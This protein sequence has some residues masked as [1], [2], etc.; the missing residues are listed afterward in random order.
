[1]SKTFIKRLDVLILILSALFLSTGTVFASATDSCASATPLELDAIYRGFADESTEFH[2]LNVPGAG[3]V[4]LDVTV[5]G[6][7]K[8]EP[9]LGFL[10]RS[11][12]TAADPDAATID[13]TAAH[14]VIAFR[15]AGQ[16]YLRVAAQDPL[17][18]L[19]DYKV[20]TRFA[21]AEIVDDSFETELGREGERFPVRQ[22]DFYVDRG[23]EP[24]ASLFTVFSPGTQNIEDEPVDPDPNGIEDEPVDPD[25]NGFA[26]SDFASKIEDEPVDPDPNGFQ[27]NGRNLDTFVV[28][29]NGIGADLCRGYEADDHGDVTDCATPLALATSATGRIGN[30]WNDDVDVFSVTLAAPASLRIATR[31]SGDTAGSLYDRFGQ[32]LAMDDDSGDGTNFR[33]AKTLESG[34]Y[35]IRVEG[36]KGAAGSYELT[37][38]ALDW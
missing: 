16:Y 29:G 38:E 33:I 32:R 18:L 10:G 35:F 36:G 9:K 2:L 24:V 11:C 31:G 21:A 26:G 12:S 25:P 3:I 1:M 28:H 14:Q 23:A 20:H 17:Q 5:P 15:A 13:K 27:G 37:A 7:A 30:D 34:Q 4:A 8:A 22:T 6:S 19:G